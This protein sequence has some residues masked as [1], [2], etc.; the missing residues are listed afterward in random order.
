MDIKAIIGN[1]MEEVL[2][3]EFAEYI[4]TL[5]IY[6]DHQFSERHN[7]KMNKLIRI[8]R[9][10]YFS[11]ISTAG[12]RAACIIVAFVVLSASALSVKAIREAFFD[13]IT[14]IF[15]D[16]NV[17]TTESGTD[18]EYPGTIEEEYYISALPEE[19]VVTDTIDTENIK[20]HSYF[21]NSDYVIFT[22]FTKSEYEQNY[23]N[24]YTEY[25]ELIDDD[26]KYLVI[27]NEY[28]TTYI[29]DNGKYIFT[30]QS[31]LDKK[32]IIDLC[33]STKVK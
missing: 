29:W 3:E 8:Q 16:H 5:P 14:S 4:N 33:K 15:S 25:K 21:R 19:F 11:L 1:A 27:E 9:K 7:R 12:R 18:S 2:D 31:N 24:E 30:I 23:D 10:P 32:D 20:Y 13:F 28:D 17:V 6:A 26:E 22:Q